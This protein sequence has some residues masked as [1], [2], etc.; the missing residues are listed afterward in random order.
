MLGN[1][2]PQRG[3]IINYY[4]SCIN[5]CESVLVAGVMTE[6]QGE[7]AIFDT[8]RSEPGPSASD[9]DYQLLVRVQNNPYDVLGDWCGEHHFLSGRLVDDD[10]LGAVVVMCEAWPG[11]GEAV[12]RNVVIRFRDDGANYLRCLIGRLMLFSLPH[13]HPVQKAFL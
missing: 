9:L 8:R 12:V 1:A 11:P 2:D 5:N 6:I 4:T 7:I 13:F 10:I 3:V